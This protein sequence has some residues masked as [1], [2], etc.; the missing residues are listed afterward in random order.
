[1]VMAAANNNE[2]TAGTHQSK[3][4]EGSLGEWVIAQEFTLE[5]GALTPRHLSFIGPILGR[6]GFLTHKHD[7][8]SIIWVFI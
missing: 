3:P 6:M 2:V 4:S 1:M 8:N 5:P 7:G